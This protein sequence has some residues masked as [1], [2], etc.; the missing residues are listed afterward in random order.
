MAL[1]AS[2]ALSNPVS[3]ELE[4]LRPSLLPGLYKNW[5][6]NSHHVKRRVFLQET[7]HAY[8]L[9]ANSGD[10]RSS[11]KYWG[12]I[13]YGPVALPYWKEK[14]PVEMGFWEMAGLMESALAGLRV[15]VLRELC[16]FAYDSF[17]PHFQW[18][19]TVEG[20][21]IGSMATLATKDSLDQRHASSLVYAEINLDILG[22][23]MSRQEAYRYAPALGA[24]LI[25]RDLAII[26]GREVSWAA[27]LG[28]ARRALGSLLREIRP[29]DLYVSKKLGADKK[30]VAFRLAFE[31]QDK[32]PS[33]QEIQNWLNAVIA[34]LAQDL[35]A[36]LRD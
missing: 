2:P 30:S 7:G 3:S 8:R 15:P 36:A 31:P 26:V 22:D 21:P 19:W 29:F 14:E 23:W 4:I 32:T 35:G 5:R 10:P 34:Q 20:R 17:H 18:D 1:E 13:S 11:V 33:A 24:D 12:A 6:Q 16:A 9:R 28:C 27:I 25:E